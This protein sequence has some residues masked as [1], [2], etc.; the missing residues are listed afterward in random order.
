MKSSN[1][2]TQTNL[3][4]RETIIVNRLQLA[5]DFI[6]PEK[7]RLQLN[8]SVR[9]NPIDLGSLAYTIRQPQKNNHLAH[10]PWLVD[11]SSLMPSRRKLLVKLHDAIVITG[12]ADSSIQAGIMGYSSIITWFDEHG[13]CDAFETE[14]NARDAYIAYVA[15]LNHQIKSVELNRIISKTANEKQRKLIALLDL[16]W[17]S[18][19]TQEI[20]CEILIIKFKRGEGEAPEE[21][22]VKFATK[23]FLH[24]A[25]GFKCFIMENKPFPYLLE[26]SDY[27]CFVF[28]SNDKACVTPYAK[29]EGF[30]YHYPDGRISTPKEY[31]LK[32]PSSKGSEKAQMNNAE[33]EIANAKNNLNFVNND[34]RNINRL[35]YATLAMQSYM[36]LFILM[37]GVNPS[38]L[39]QLEYDDSFTLEKDLLKNDFRAIKMRAAGREVAY[40]LGNRKG[41]EIFKEY[42]ELR[43]WVLDG[44][45]CPYLFFTMQR[46]T[47][48]FLQYRANS[49]YRVYRSLRGKFLP[50]S[51]TAITANKVRKYKTVVWNEIGVAQEVIADG[52]NH[53]IGTNQKVYAVSSPDKQQA[54]FGLFFEATKAAAKLITARPEAV[55]RIPV[56]IRPESDNSSSSTTKIGSGTCIDFQH[57]EPMET[58]P[59]IIPDC[60]SQMGCL[61]CEHYVCHSDEEDIK[62][63]YSLLYVIEAVRNMAIDFNHSDKLLLELTVRIQLVLTQ[64]T[65]KSDDIKALVEKIKGDVMQHGLLTPFW[66]FKLQRYEQMG[67]VI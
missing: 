53:E 5:Q 22:K 29:A 2:A 66:E 67:V 40:H 57:P 36:Q 20:I 61:Y 35:N 47:E 17:G 33:R 23:T 6:H 43:S 56:K 13:H 37:T 25:R 19:S 24:L 60:K 31:L 4:E 16:Y 34:T 63:L 1:K 11:E 38:E 55:E 45:Y 44:V 64:M 30:S 7:I 10:L 9:V 28:P 18:E 12:N 49:L 51:F 50:S 14:E 58:E 21:A 52:L 27:E 48:N 65:A 32:N 59:P 42:I 8:K 3:I 26:M 15:E 39:I 62:K 41:L 54:E 46:Y